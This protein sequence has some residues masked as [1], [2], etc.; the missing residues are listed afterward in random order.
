MVASQLT[1]QGFDVF[2]PVISQL[3]RWSDRRKLVEMPLFSGYTF[4]RFVYFS[5]DRV[6]ILQS[7][8]VCGIVS[9]K[10]VGL[11]IPE[12][13]IAGIR[14]LLAHNI[15]FKEYPF[16]KVGQRIRIRGGA[17]DGLRGI[18]LAVNGSRSLVISV[19]PIQRSICVQIGDYHIESI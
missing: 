7:H 14:T 16:L 11:P 18:L 2:L 6:R 3:R 4:A 9:A 17:L 13:Q 10:G 12:D 19:E 1:Q 15:P 8:G 5:A